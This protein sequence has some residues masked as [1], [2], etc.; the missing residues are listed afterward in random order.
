MTLFVNWRVVFKGL[1][2]QLGLLIGNSLTLK[3]GRRFTVRFMCVWTI[4][5]TIILI[6]SRNRD[7]MM[8]GR[9]L[10]YLYIGM[11]LSVIPLYQAEITPAQ[12]RGAMVASYN[13]ALL[14][15]MLIMSLICYGT[16]EIPNRTSYILPIGLFYIIPTI[17]LVCT[18]WMPESP[19][20]LVQQG[21]FDEALESLQRLRE[22]KFSEDEIAQELDTIKAICEEHDQSREG[23]EGF[24]T[25]WLRIWTKKHI[26]RTGIVLGTNFFL[27]GTGNAFS[28]MYGTIFYRSIG[29]MNPFALTCISSVATLIASTITLVLVD[30][31]GRRP[32]ILLGSSVQTVALLIMGGLGMMSTTRAISGGIIAMM[33]I[34]GMGYCIAWGQL[35]HTITAE[36]PSAEVRDLT[37]VTGSLL[38]ICTQAA[39]TFG[40]PYLL[41]KPY[42]GLGPRVGFIFGSLAAVSV[43]FAFFCLPECKG[44]SLEEI[45]R[46]FN[47][48]VPVRKFKRTTLDLA[49]PTG[50]NK[51]RE[52]EAEGDVKGAGVHAEIVV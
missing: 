48:K 49:E 3:M 35:S 21:R 19:R 20:W 8:A 47:M 6:T 33:M 22:G 29:T 4:L 42:A 51:N 28:S 13:T 7:Q 34:F 37:Y 24:A 39:N 32:I 11:E 38:A 40:L 50:R 30:R 31:V 45:D 46:L 52:E 44:K 5:C 10:N 36:I 41:N 43:V 18:F 17:V 25:R 27:H 12:A 15:G 9:A 2:T 26:K 23:R 1:H 16:S 14:L